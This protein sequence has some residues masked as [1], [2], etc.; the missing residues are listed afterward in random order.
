MPAR[1][2]EKIDNIFA[3]ILFA[4]AV[5]LLRPAGEAL[6]NTPADWRFFDSSDGLVESWTRCVSIGPDGKVWATHGDVAELSWMDGW[7]GPDGRFVHTLPSPGSNMKAYESRSGQLWSLYQNGIELYREGKWNQFKVKGVENNYSTDFDGISMLNINRVSLL[8]SK[9]NKALYLLPDCLMSFDAISGQ[10][11]PVIKAEATKLG[12]FIDMIP[13]SEGSLWITGQRGIGRLEQP[14]EPH[15][16]I[17]HEYLLESMGVKDFQ[18]PTTGPDKELFAVAVN[19]RSNKKELIHFDGMKWNEFSCHGRDVLKGWLGLEGSYWI[20]TERQQLSLVQNGTEEI[21]EKVGILAGDLHD[22]AIENDGIFWLATSQGLARFA[23]SIWRTPGALKGIKDR[24]HA[25]YEDSQGRIWFAAVFHLLLYQEGS[26]KIYALPR[27]LET[28]PFFTQS[29]CSLPDGRIAIGVIPYQYFLLV[30]NPATEKF[31]FI[32]H[33]LE[34]STGQSQKSL[35]RLIAPRKDGSIWVETNKGEGSGKVC[36]EIFDGKNFQSCLELKREWN[37]TNLRYI[38]EAQDGAVWIGGVIGKSLLK[39]KDG[40]AKIFGPSDGYSGVGGFCIAE[41]EGGKIWVGGR[42]NISE[43]DGRKWSVVRSGLA[44]VR[45]IVRGR[46]GSIWVASGTGVHRFHEGAWIVYTNEDGLPNTV[47]FKIFEDSEGRIWAGTIQG[48]GLYHPEADTDPPRT[49]IS[50]KENLKDAAPDGNVRLIFSGADRWKQT[51][52]EHLLYSYRLNDGPW[53]VFKTGTVALFNNLS[54]GM[55]RFEVRAMDNNL[56]IDPRPAVFEFTVLL[57]WYKEIGFQVVAAAGTTIIVILLGYAIHRHVLLEKLVVK[58]TRD[59]QAANLHLQEN[60]SELERADRML[61]QEHEKLELTLE[62]E[63]LLAR[64]AFRLN[65]TDAFPGPMDELLDMIGRATGINSIGIYSLDPGLRKTARLAHWHSA[66][67]DQPDREFEEKNISELLFSRVNGLFQKVISG[68]SVAISDFPDANDKKGVQSSRLPGSVFMLPVGTADSIMGCISLCRSSRY[69][70]KPEERNLFSTIAAMIA[71]AWRR[72]EYLQERL[73]ADRKRTEAIQM[74]EKTARLASIGVMAAGITHEINQPLNSIRIISEGAILDHER[75]K[76]K[77]PEEKILTFRK[78]FQ[79]VRRIE[80]VIR[81]MR[82]FWINPAE[83]IQEAIDLNESV[84]SALSLVS[85]QIN[86]HEIELKLYLHESP[87]II[88]GN[89]VHLE[90]IV[91]NLLINAIHALDEL[92]SEAKTI[93]ILTHLVEGHAVLEIEDNGKG[94]PAGDE[95]EIFEPF[96]T[97][98]LP[99]KGVGLGLAIV[100]KFVEGMN[101]TISARKS[102]G[103]GAIFT[104]ELQ[105]CPR[106]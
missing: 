90:Q 95:E 14:D 39:Y 93:K 85:T 84:E 81:H 76:G 10:N 30:F 15:G 54:H 70:W 35:I 49:L 60:Y 11:E 1:L 94:I 65:S 79:Q 88:Q 64:I 7:P 22:V 100:K 61:K 91:I 53:S 72:Y 99:E 74:A 34:D 102:S 17:W 92:V 32:R 71:N 46:D 97:T 77:R 43:F 24:I 101:G 98:K 6:G 2:V 23:P 31:E 78:I 27:N 36:L 47:V 44:G 105:T 19:R 45:S 25:I 104:V 28:Q 37:V 96:Y 86:S 26:W 66:T 63:R 62:H 75:K 48:L 4:G 58:R 21:Q 41:L 57:P 87:L 29:L 9:N 56:N 55:H 5:M 59:L 83:S 38:F 67:A 8:P 20:S 3:L 82:T 50:S 69:L 13:G 16:R 68:E 73:E 33:S 51:Q 12:G 103:S 89:R 40:K 80:D 42:D 106:G 52:L 18:A